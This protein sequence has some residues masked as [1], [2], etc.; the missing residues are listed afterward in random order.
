LKFHS[1]ASRGVIFLPGFTPLIRADGLDKM[2]SRLKKVGLGVLILVLISAGNMRGQDASDMDQSYFA[3][4]TMGGKQFWS[5]ELFFH[6]WRI[7]RNVFTGHY[8][9][10]D[11]NDRRHASGTYHDCRQALDEIKRNRNLPPMKGK[12][13]IVLHGLFRSRSSMSSLCD[14]LAERG[15]Y[16]VFNMTY[17]ST[18]EDIGEHARALAHIVDHL[19]GIEE[20]SLVG[21]SMGNIVIRH[22]L[23][24]LK[25]QEAEKDQG[26]ED[27][28]PASP[29]R[30]AFHRF[31]MLAPP[32]H[33]AQVATTFGNNFLYQTISGQAG[34]QLGRQWSEFEPMLAT[35]DFEFAIIAGGKNNDKGYNPWLAGDN[36]GTISVESSKLAGARDFIVLPVLHTFI[37][38]DSKAQEMTLEFLQKGFFTSED[39]RRPLN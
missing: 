23:G 17:S 1:A 31:V 27:T 18:R 14:F 25:R 24:D 3:M 34:Q 13:V 8:R 29:K 4:P 36:D 26:P 16:E 28:E 33:E 15:G 22:Y 9:L 12:A 21:H 2:L 30:P 10:L 5:D 20:L 32:N 38:N 11:E 35:P 37:M 39:Q 6:Q 7:Q 19:D